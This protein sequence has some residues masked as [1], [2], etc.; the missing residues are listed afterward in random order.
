MRQRYQTTTYKAC[1]P[2][3]SLDGNASTPMDQEDHSID[4]VM[5]LASPAD[6]IVRWQGSQTANQA[7]DGL[8]V[9][10]SNPVRRCTSNFLF[11]P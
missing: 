11:L 6:D 3:L 8:I 1:D 10:A 9:E 2:P 5:S 7:L 4:Q